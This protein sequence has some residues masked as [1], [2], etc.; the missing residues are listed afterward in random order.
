[1]KGRIIVALFLSCFFL[2]QAAAQD[3]SELDRLGDK[4]NRHLETRMSGWKHKRREPIQ[5]SKNVLIEFWASSN[6]VVKVSVVPYKSAQEASEVLRGFLKYDTQKEELKGFGDEAF[7]WGY[8][9]SNVVF[10]RGKLI[11]Y[12]STYAE[13]DSDPEARSLTERERGERERVEMRRLSR[14]FAKLMADAMN[15]P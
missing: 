12:V 15:L 10:T 8:G 3:Q 7:G 6:R 5:G 11:V 1:M 2:S 14:E 4:F 13:V 9:M